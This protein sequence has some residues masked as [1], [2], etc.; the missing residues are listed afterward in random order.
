[1]FFFENHVFETENTCV[2]FLTM[3]IHVGLEIRLMGSKKG[4][5]GG[6]RNICASSCFK[7]LR[8]AYYAYYA[9]SC[10]NAA[11]MAYKKHINHMQQSPLIS[12]PRLFQ[13]RFL[14]HQGLDLN[15]TG[16]VLV[17]TEK[18]GMRHICAHVF[19]SHLPHCKSLLK[20]CSCL[21]P[22]APLC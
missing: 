2:C 10:F 6:Y 15:R 17:L 1:M 21:L 20:V 18:H 3:P 22:F 13:E 11:A 8:N 12:Y 4:G 19:S 7:K 16:L 5:K 9:S 14:L